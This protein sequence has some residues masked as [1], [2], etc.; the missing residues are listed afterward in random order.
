MHKT[1]LLRNYIVSFMEVSCA[2]METF[3]TKL[4]ARNDATGT[5]CSILQGLVINLLVC[6]SKWSLNIYINNL[7]GNEKSYV[8]MIDFPKT[9]SV[10]SSW[11]INW[12][13]WITESTIKK[14]PSV[15][16]RDCVYEKKSF[17]PTVNE[18]AVESIDD[19]V[20]F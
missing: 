2:V 1:F 6:A 11:D 13:L 14:T 4:T 19:N 9:L 12:T 15:S 7:V 5:G 18:N 17:F 10:T 16:T 3:S 8:K 20:N